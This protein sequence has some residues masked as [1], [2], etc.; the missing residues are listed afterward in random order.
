M[1]HAGSHETLGGPRRPSFPPAPAGGTLEP[2]SEVPRLPPTMVAM[3]GLPARGKSYIAAR[4]ARL[5]RWRGHRCR[6][7]N[8]GS[9]RRR[10]VGPEQSHEFFD[11]DNH[12]ARQTR[13]QVAVLALEDAIGWLDSGGEVA[14]YDATNITHARRE[15]IAASCAR[16][17]TQLT[18]IETVC[19]DPELIEA[20]IR[21]SKLASP[22][23]AGWSPEEAARDFRMRIAHYRR[24][25]EPLEDGA[26]YIRLEGP[27]ER[28][29]VNRPGGWV[30]VRLCPLLFS[31]RPHAAPLWLARH[32]ESAHNVEGRIGGNAPLSTR[33]EAFARELARF[34][35]AAD[36]APQVVWTSTL[37]RTRQTAE[38][39]G[40]RH[41]PRRELDEIGAGICEGMTYDEIRRELPGEW[42]ARAADKLRYR[43]PRGE[44]YLDLIARLEPLILDIERRDDPLLI[45]GHQAVLRAVYG[46]LSGH[47]AEECP[48]LAI[49]LHTVI[50][51]T[52]GPDG[53]EET[54]IP[55]GPSV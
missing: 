23:Y 3:V 34:V 50:A 27:G 11:F 13:N 32:G 37:L 38:Q 16:S 12:S 4:V 48:S 17:G 33:G 2:A 55:L 51:L 43:Y 40:C 52:E 21:G 10:V 35:A 28:V 49:P 24:A 36:P 39:L 47:P 1:S 53:I 46:Y 18:F 26:S 22:D 20:N 44:S 15:L 9:Y 41:S 8:V 54:R 5:L 31:L 6:V 14:I 29:V 19:E 30:P 7:F 42:Q 45:I 25:Y